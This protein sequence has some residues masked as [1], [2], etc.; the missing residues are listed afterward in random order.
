MPE[1]IR[2]GQLAAELGVTVDDVM[3]RA[4]EILSRRFGSERVRQQHRVQVIMW[5]QGSPYLAEHFAIAIR[6]SFSSS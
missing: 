4:D 5:R 2:A 3:G 6:K 1:P